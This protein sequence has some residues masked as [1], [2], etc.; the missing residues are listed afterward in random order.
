MVSKAISNTISGQ[1]KRVFEHNNHITLDYVYAASGVPVSTVKRA[2]DGV[3][4]LREGTAYKLAEFL[5][6]ETSGEVSARDLLIEPQVRDFSGRDLR[7]TRYL[8]G[9]DLT[10]YRFCGADLKGADLSYT[11][12]NGVDFRAADMD[13]VNATGAYMQRWDLRGVAHTAGMA[14][15]S[16]T[17]E[18]TRLLGAD[19]RDVIWKNVTARIGGNHTRG[20][21][22]DPQKIDPWQFREACECHELVIIIL[23]QLFPSDRE[24]ME[25]C[26]CISGRFISCWHGLVMRMQNKYPHR[27][28]DLIWAWSVY[29]EWRLSERWELGE[30]MAAC[31]TIEDWEGLRDTHHFERFPELVIGWTRKARAG[32][33]MGDGMQYFLPSPIAV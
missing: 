26:E 21:L 3:G 28:P 6:N 5:E 17:L 30:A 1:L 23:L 25:I 11:T 4:C 8:H 9:E 18:G 2:K 32:V 19:L 20:A 7:G 27:I 31:K 22:F 29:P 13:E 16:C 10:G 12:G 15:V 33:P 14:L 24:I